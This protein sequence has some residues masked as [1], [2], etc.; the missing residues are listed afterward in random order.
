MAVHSKTDARPERMQ[1]NAV[2]KII[3]RIGK[4]ANVV[5]DWKDLPPGAKDQ[6][7]CR[8][9]EALMIYVDRSGSDGPNE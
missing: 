8:C 1:P 3:G 7:P 4:A 6:S 9:S 2:G 5:V